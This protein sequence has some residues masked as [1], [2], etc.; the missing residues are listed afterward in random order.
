MKKAVLIAAALALAPL[1]LASQEVQDRKDREPA[2]AGKG[3]E[4]AG[5]SGR[6][7]DQAQSALRDRVVRAIETIEEACAADLDDLCGRVTSGEG[8]IAMCMRAHEDQI[9][10][11]CRSALYRVTGTLRGNIDRVVEGC[12]NEIQAQCGDAGKIGPCLEQKKSSFSSS[13][14]RIIGALEQRMHHR[15]SLV[16]MSVYSSDNKNLGQIV[17]VVRGPNDELRSVQVDIGRMLGLGTKVVTI[18]IEKL[19][20]VPGIKALLSDTEVRSLPEA[21]K[22]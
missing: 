20:Q 19:Q 21:K 12:W 22:Q 13:C 7:D 14:Q 16:G 8:R 11:G 10:S 4:Q 17:E 6:V 15:T 1:P 18:P 3:G 2:Y 5:T 9:S